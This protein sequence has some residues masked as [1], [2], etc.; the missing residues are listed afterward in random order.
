MGIDDR[1][2]RKRWQG[3]EEVRESESGE[4]LFK[5]RKEWHITRNKRRK[6]TKRRNYTMQQIVC[7]SPAARMSSCCR[8]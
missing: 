1:G 3:V 5:K 6:Y 2:G 8:G 4:N 7:T